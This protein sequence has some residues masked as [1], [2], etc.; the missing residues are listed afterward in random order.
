MKH[1]TIKS[2]LV[3][4]ITLSFT[5][6][7]YITGEA[8][9]DD[10]VSS[11]SNVVSSLSETVS[12]FNPAI[13]QMQSNLA[14]TYWETTSSLNESDFLF[15]PGNFLLG[16]IFSAMDDDYDYIFGSID[17]MRDNP[18]NW[19]KIANRLSLYDFFISNNSLSF[20]TTYDNGE[21]EILL[22]S[23]SFSFTPDGAEAV[24]YIHNDRTYAHVL[25]FIYINDTQAVINWR[26]GE[27]GQ[28]GDGPYEYKRRI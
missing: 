7:K 15:D 21:R 11:I 16:M 9:I 24:F 3:I 1:K 4:V 8:S 27:S 26:I 14:N 28:D 10:L 23:D 2:L 25:E 12:S 20:Y 6:C 13:T 17:S 18:E 19:S 22:T 5:G